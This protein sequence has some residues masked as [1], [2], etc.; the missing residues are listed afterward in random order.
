MRKK[1]VHTERFQAYWTFLVENRFD[2]LA[3]IMSFHKSAAAEALE[4]IQLD[5]EILN[6]QLCETCMRVPRRVELPHIRPDREP[7]TVEER[8][9]RLYKKP[10]YHDFIAEIK[11]SKRQ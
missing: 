4:Q 5:A 3:V 1:V 2:A 8:I 10:Q 7:E 11:R 9:D 6:V